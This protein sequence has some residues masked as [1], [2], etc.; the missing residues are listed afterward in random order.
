MPKAEHS[1]IRSKEDLSAS[2]FPVILHVYDLSNSN[3]FLHAF[4]VGIYHTGVQIKDQE[5]MFAGHPFDSSGVLCSREPKHCLLEN[6]TYRESVVI[7]YCA[8]SCAQ[9]NEILGELSREYLGT[10]YNL[11]A[12]N[13]NHFSNDLCIRLTGRCIPGWINRAASIGKFLGCI[14]PSQALPSPPT[15]SQKDGQQCQISPEH[16]STFFFFHSS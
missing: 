7:S 11:L 9:V 13:C 10:A 12:R 2:V 14:V 15:S 5:F 8:L 6:A 3:T 4:G 16:A 1:K